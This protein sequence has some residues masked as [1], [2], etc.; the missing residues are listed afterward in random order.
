MNDPGAQ[1]LM[2]KI[3]ED[4]YDPTNVQ[5]LIG[6]G[7]GL[8]NTGTIDA[9]IWS[10]NLNDVTPYSGYWINVEG[11]YGWNILFEND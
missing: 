7:V 3:I 9:P 6:Q 11:I 2:N 4:E 1:Q 5:F 8:F 10:G